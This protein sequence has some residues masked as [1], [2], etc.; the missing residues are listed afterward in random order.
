VKLNNHTLRVGGS[1]GTSGLGTLTMQNPND[2]LFVTG[3][4][5]FAGASTSGLLTNGAITLGGNFVE[6]GTI[7][8]SFAPTGTTVILAGTA[9]QLVSFSNSGPAGSRFFNVGIANTAAGGG[10]VLGTDVYVL[11]QI[12]ILPTAVRTIHSS[13]STLHLANLNISDPLGAVFDNALLD[14]DVA[15]GGTFLALSNVT[16]Q[17][18]ATSA[19]VLSFTHPGTAA[20][21]INLTNVRFLTTITPGTGFYVSATDS[22][23]ATPFALTLLVTSNG[24]PGQ[25]EGNAHVGVS[26]GAT[27]SFQN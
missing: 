7:T 11:G 4:A 14:F 16:F 6:A 23:G 3:P 1:F 27:V 12:A 13:G 18:Y 17:N 25:T 20:G 10:V 8:T 22:D 26:G 2:S 9:S 24:F 19:K 5:V 15:L 21:P